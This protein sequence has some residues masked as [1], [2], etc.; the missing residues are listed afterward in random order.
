M[1][2]HAQGQH[3]A[4]HVWLRPIGIPAREL[5]FPTHQCRGDFG[6]LGH[7]D[8]NDIFIPQSISALSNRNIVKI[9]CGDTHTLAVTDTGDLFAFGRNQNGQLGIGSTN[10]ALLPHPV[11][12][13]KVCLSPSRMHAA[14]W[15]AHACI[16]QCA[17]A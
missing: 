16:S 8:C 2:S 15:A 11:E 12:A 6:R 1:G 7:G 10:D 4:A 13:L 17:V 3:P 14:C 5:R 9:A